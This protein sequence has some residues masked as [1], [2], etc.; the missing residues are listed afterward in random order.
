M[1]QKTKRRLGVTKDS[2]PLHGLSTYKSGESKM[3]IVLE[4]QGARL[5]QSHGKIWL[6]P[7]RPQG[8]TGDM[9]VHIRHQVNKHGLLKRSLG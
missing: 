6:H 5:Y 8:D 3:E 4:S 7:Y 1:G 2:Q 9:L